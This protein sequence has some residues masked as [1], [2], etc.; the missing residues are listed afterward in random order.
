M[1]GF[2]ALAQEQAVKNGDTSLVNQ[3]YFILERIL[4]PPTEV[5]F[6]PPSTPFGGLVEG[7]T[8]YVFQP[9]RFRPK[10]SK[11]SYRSA[12]VRTYECRLE[13]MV[14]P[15]GTVASIFREGHDCRFSLRGMSVP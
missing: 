2:P 8:K 9:V 13:I 3:P 10:H 5:V 4:P 15:D 6:D 7:Y 1:M 14:R 11:S 12:V